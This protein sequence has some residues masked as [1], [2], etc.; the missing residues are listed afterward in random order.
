MTRQALISGDGDIRSEGHDDH[1]WNASPPRDMSNGQGSQYP[2]PW[3]RVLQSPPAA[4][5]RARGGAVLPLGVMVGQPTQGGQGE[6]S[7]ATSWWGHTMG[8]LEPWISPGLPLQCSQKGKFPPTSRTSVRACN[9]TRM[10]DVRTRKPSE[11]S[12]SRVLKCCYPP[13]SLLEGRGWNTG[14]Q[15]PSEVLIQWVGGEP[16][17][18][19]PSLPSSVFSDFMLVAWNWPWWEYL[20]TPQTLTK[21]YK[22]GHYVLFYFALESLLWM[23]SHHG[24]CGSLFSS[25]LSNYNAGLFE[26][27]HWSSN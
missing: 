10:K 12:G 19:C 11:I 6:G 13:E 20:F 5:R 14:H 16:E 8:S 27:K 24:L 23:T 7:L 3:P 26:K 4:W 15:A 25:I 2:Q 22:S 9:V 1:S 17:P 21:Y 18:R